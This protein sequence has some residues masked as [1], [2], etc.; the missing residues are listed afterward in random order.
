MIAALAAAVTGRRGRWVTIPVWVLLAV[1][2]IP[3]ENWD[4]ERTNAR[5]TRLIVPLVLPV[6]GLI[7][8]LLL[9]ALAAPLYLIATVVLSFAGSLG[10]ATF[11]FAHLGSEGVT[12]TSPC[13]P[14][15]SSSRSASTTT[16]S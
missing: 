16:S 3:A 13:S 12:S 2:G 7:L 8:M 5:D 15:S 10:L 1:G 4:I 9:R 11:A 6:V 14:S